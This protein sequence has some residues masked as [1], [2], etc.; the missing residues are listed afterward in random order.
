MSPETIISNSLAGRGRLPVCVVKIRSVLRI[1]KR[2]FGG[3]ASRQHP[4]HPK[5]M[6]REGGRGKMYSGTPLGRPCRQFPAGLQVQTINPGRVAIEDLVS[7]IGV[8]AGEDA[9]DGLARLGPRRVGM[10]EVA[11]PQV[12]VLAE[13]LDR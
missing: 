5:H 8:D 2:P 7:N 9:L 4:R 10:R 13:Q 12:V 3:C 6:A 11:A 1:M